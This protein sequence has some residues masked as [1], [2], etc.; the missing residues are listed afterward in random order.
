MPE[1]TTNGSGT[2][3]TTYYYASGQLLALAINSEFSYLGNDVL[4][5]A[6]VALAAGGT[7]QA[8]VMYAPLGDC[9]RDARHRVQ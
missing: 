5:S 3:T 2:T 6:D 7:E 8:S 1:V 9:C 4:G